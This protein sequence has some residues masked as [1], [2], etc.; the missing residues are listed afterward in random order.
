MVNSEGIREFFFEDEEDTSSSNIDNPLYEMAS[1]GYFSTDE[2][3]SQP[4]NAEFKV[5]V[6]GGEGDEPHIHIWDNTTSGRRFH[7]CIC[8]NKVAYFHHTGKEG[9]LTKKQKKRLV[10]FLK[11]ECVKNKRY[12]TNWE[13]ALSMWNDNNTDKTQVDE[14]AEVLDYT[15]L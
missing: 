14:S 3:N 9:V 6:N 13:Y 4:Q 11:A 7:T 1:V 2:T 8:L 10:E 5:F 12:K 15:L